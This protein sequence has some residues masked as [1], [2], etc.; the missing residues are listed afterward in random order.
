MPSS[1]RLPRFILSDS[2]PRLCSFSWGF[3]RVDGLDEAGKEKFARI[4]RDLA[5]DSSHVKYLRNL[6]G[7]CG[8]KA[9]IL[10]KYAQFGLTSID[11]MVHAVDN[12]QYY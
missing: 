12:R 10:A 7:K 5:M 2:I 1:R 3:E 9:M 4:T 11:R 6:P 8:V